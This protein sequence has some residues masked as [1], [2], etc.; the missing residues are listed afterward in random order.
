MHRAYGL[1]FRQGIHAV[2]EKIDDA[3]DGIPAADRLKG[4]CHV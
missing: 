1:R 3:I 2:I 4:G